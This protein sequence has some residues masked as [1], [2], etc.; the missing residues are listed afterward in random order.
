M[1]SPA[2]ASTAA[3]VA[4]LGVAG[5]LLVLVTWSASIGPDGVVS[6]RSLSRGVLR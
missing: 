2:R 3:V 6:A 1:A 5:L 4:V